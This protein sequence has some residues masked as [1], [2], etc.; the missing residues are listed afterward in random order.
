[1][2][3]KSTTTPSGRGMWNLNAHLLMHVVHFVRERCS[4]LVHEVNQG[5]RQVLRDTAYTLGTIKYDDVAITLFMFANADW[6]TG[7][8]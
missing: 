5:C 8:L 3:H 2:V 6:K 7:Q 1:M 4:P